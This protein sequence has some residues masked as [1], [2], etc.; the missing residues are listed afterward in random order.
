MISA[1]TQ[2][3]RR[4]FGVND[5]MRALRVHQWLKNLLIFL[6]PL[7]AHTLSIDAMLNS[8]LAFLSFC[9]C[10]SGV[11][12]LNDLIDLDSDRQHPTKRLRPLAA[13]IIPLKVGLILSPV[14]TGAAVVLALW[15][16]GRF[17]LVLAGYYLLALGYALWL[18]RWMMIDVVVL[19]CLYGIRVAAGG[20]ATEV[21][22]SVWLVAF[23]LFLFFSLALV[24]RCAELIERAGRGSG[25]VPGRGYHQNDLASLESMATTSGYL[26]VLVLALYINNS[27]VGRLYSAPDVLWL[28]CIILLYWIGRV[29][30][31][32]HRGQMLEDPVVFA[33]TDRV[34]LLLGGLSC[35]VIAGASLL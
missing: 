33:A 28:M 13:G 6:P 18:K 34:S 25:E 14:L 9:F 17:L 5:L 1:P 31:L 16:P 12:L 15:L 27:M 11:Y 32:T 26:S 10:A 7:A 23:S 29:L 22:L 2:Q 8:L 24:K 19:A 20:A 21:P 35:A 4:R 30:L 3:G